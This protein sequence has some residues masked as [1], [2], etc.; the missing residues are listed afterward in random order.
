[1]EDQDFIL[2]WVVNFDDPSPNLPSLE[3]NAMQ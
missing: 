1:M 2:I 3:E